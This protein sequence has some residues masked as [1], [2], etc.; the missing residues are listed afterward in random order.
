MKDFFLRHGKLVLQRELLLS[1]G[2]EVYFRQGSVDH[3]IA[4]LSSTLDTNALGHDRFPRNVRD[5]TDRAEKI[6]SVG[7]DFQL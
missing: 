4:V 1:H 7:V 5:L 2:D 3:D 6:P